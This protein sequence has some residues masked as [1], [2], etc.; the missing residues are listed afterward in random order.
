MRLWAEHLRMKKADVF[1]PIG[2]ARHWAAPPLKSFVAV[3]DHNADKNII[4]GP[5]NV[6]DPFG[7]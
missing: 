3:Y 6:V 2:S 7:G 1:D 4:E 5:D